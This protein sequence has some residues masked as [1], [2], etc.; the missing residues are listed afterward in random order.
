MATRYLSLCLLLFLSFSSL[1]QKDGQ[2]LD[3]RALNNFLN[4][5]YNE[6]IEEC[7]TI[8]EKHSDDKTSNRTRLILARCYMQ[9]QQYGDALEVLS[10]T[11]LDAEFFAMGIDGMM[12]DCKSQQGKHQE[13]LDY[14]LKAI[15][16]TPNELLTPHYLVKTY[17]CSKELNLP[18]EANQY[19]QTAI[20]YFP[21]YAGK[22][23]LQK[24]LTI[25]SVT[26]LVLTAEEIQQPKTLGIGTV[27]GKSVSENAYYEAL[28][29][30]QQNAR[31][32]ALQS[33]QLIQYVDPDRVWMSFAEE[34]ALTREYDRLSLFTDNEEMMAYLLAS[35]GYSVQSEFLNSPLFTDENG[36]FDRA[37]LLA[38]ID[39]MRTSE[40]PSDVEAWK[41]TANYYQEKLR[42]EKYF[43]MIGVIQFVTDLEVESA[44]AQNKV[45]KAQFF[46]DRYRDFPNDKISSS[47]QE[48]KTYYE[49]NKFNSE[50][51]VK[52]DQ[53]EVLLLR[54]NIAPTKSDTSLAYEKA[55]RLKRMFKKA[56]NDSAF[57]VAWSD[58]NFYTSGPYSSAVPLDHEQASTG[59]YIVYP[60]QMSSAFD[61]AKIGDVIGPY[62]YNGSLSIAKVIGRTD[63]VINAR[64][65]LLMTRGDSGG[66]S[67]EEAQKFFQTVTNENFTELAK[68]HSEDKGSAEQGG[69]LGDFFFGEM[70]PEFATFCTDTPVGEIGFVQSQYGYHIVQVTERRGKKFPRL[71]LV[72]LPIELSDQSYSNP[73]KLLEE[74]TSNYKAQKVNSNSSIASV[75]DSIAESLGLF[76]R[77]VR[78]FDNSPICYF[79]DTQL[80]EDKFHQFAFDSTTGIGEISPI[81]RDSLS[82]YSMILGGVR[83]KG[84][85]S[86]EMVKE[87]MLF[88]FL[89]EKKSEMIQKQFSSLSSTQKEKRKKEVEI[90]LANLQIPSCG[91]EP[92]VI[93]KAIEAY[94]Q[95][96][97]EIIVYGVSGVFCIQV[98]K[99][100][101]HNN[102]LSKEELSAQ[103][104]RTNKQDIYAFARMALKQISQIVDNRV[105][106]RLNI[107][108]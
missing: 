51:Q 90:S 38:R 73:K 101:A 91:Y 7:Q 59:K 32:Q 44:K 93:G 29:I 10:K 96:Q 4:A 24:H 58:L 102:T 20:D 45:Y 60:E 71:A 62:D 40:E 26:P 17:L 106:Y 81:Y 70:V 46:C 72:V 74:F 64:H 13:A 1:S 48:L 8:L 50:Y 84:I 36:N 49:R 107:R 23:A 98:T 54:E 18:R 100:L 12:G 95:N 67:Y 47:N 65:I 41:N 63:E 76:V 89:K 3:W 15:H 68:S 87:Q 61:K 31:L 39:E 80:A 103:I 16:S 14:Y 37:K 19:I 92:Y 34:E 108:H 52:R 42:Q 55:K 75:T 99:E 33:G 105:L 97:G 94:Y 22:Y 69:E 57:V 43:N 9:T 85:P 21:A 30:A 25:D 6:A 83:K 104:D 86:F 35:D 77:K 79:F 66:Y 2:N 88:E 56:K 27:N 78:T 11:D 5:E 82:F 53:R 28:Q